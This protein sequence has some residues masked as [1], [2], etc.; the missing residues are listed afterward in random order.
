MDRP[1]KILVECPALIAS[2][3]VGVLEPLK[4]LE[5]Q[6]KC[7]VRFLETM[8]IKKSDIAWCDIIICVRGFEYVSLKVVEA[9][10]KAGR[11]VIYFL[12]D[13]LI[14][15]P[16]GISSTNYFSDEDQK[17][18]LIRLMEVSDVLWCVN[19]LIGEKYSIYGNG[20]WIISRVPVELPPQL[21]RDTSDNT[22]NVLYAGSVDH[23]GLIQEYI[24]PVV[25]RMCEEFGDSLNFTFIGADP[26]LEKLSNVRHYGFFDDY[27][28]YRKVLSD[29]RYDIGLAPIYT[30]EFYQCKYYSKFIEYTTQ[31]V[32]GI[33]TKC[34]PYTSIVE[35][36]KN[37][38][39]CENTF[40]GWYN[41]LKRA[42][43]DRKLRE[44]CVNEARSLMVS[45]FCPHEVAER[46]AEDI[47]SLISFRAPE[48]QSKD[49]F[50]GNMFRLFYRKRVELL[51]KQY[52]L[53]A[54]PIIIWKL[55]K[56]CFRIFQK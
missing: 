37:G 5:Q 41:T 9:A 18:S 14:N 44:H 10:K 54:V 22:T 31:G 45:D 11:Y 51:W 56:K 24:S 13:D 38:F 12:D 29:C 30:T 42:F 17:Q 7:Q 15:I 16:Q 46:L 47:P 53:T 27:D 52:G 28:E 2:V 4:P 19:P 34:L 23:S 48:L 32:A 21:H 43:L 33:Y 40:D 1:T 26:K 6:W 50:L 39:L 25:T 55:L 49:I 35:H 36:N 8:K 3:R 20:K